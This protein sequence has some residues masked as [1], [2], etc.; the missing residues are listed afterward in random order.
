MKGWFTEF[1]TPHVGITIRIKE[2]LYDGQTKYQKIDVIDTPEFGKILL[3]DNLIMITDRDEY[4]Y[5]EM[6]TH[7]PLL[8]HKEPKTVLVIGGGDGGV[9]REICKHPYIERIDQA[10]IDEEVISTARR[11]FPK[12]ACEYD[13][14]KVNV[15]ITDG[16]KFVKEH[17]NE[18]DIIVVDSTD[19]FGPGKVL[20][21]KEFYRRVFQALRP[22]GIMTAQIGTPFY[23]A[24]HVKR[25]FKKLREVFPIALPYMAH[26]PTYTD[27]YYC[28]AF[29]SKKYHPL[30]HF[31]KNRYQSLDLNC[32][33]YNPDI[34]QGA[35]LLPTYVAK[36]MID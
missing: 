13:N 32:K 26:I 17:K 15:H 20:F 4:V 21:C 28:L 2:H 25:T 34:Q 10:E 9:I 35:F 27:G 3:L 19:P 30:K 29:C 24:T 1:H 5:H 7:I 22:D 18:Y 14:P 33:Y 31:D 36:L 16:F 6:M 23:N 12:V 8:T 11:F